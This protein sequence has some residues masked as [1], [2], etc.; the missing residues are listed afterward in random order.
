MNFS[1]LQMM[2]E[3]LQTNPEILELLHR[4]RE[5]IE[6]ELKLRDKLKALEVRGGWGPHFIPQ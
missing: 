4:G 1:E 3:V 6:Q 5:Q 2:L